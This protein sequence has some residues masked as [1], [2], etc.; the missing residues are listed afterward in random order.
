MAY[1]DKI[2][3]TEQPPFVELYTITIGEEVGLY[4]SAKEDVTHDFN[5]YKAR[6]IKRGD[7]KVTKDLRSTRLSIAAPLEPYGLQF[8]S[9]APCEP[10]NIKIVRLFTDDNLDFIEV[11]NGTVLSVSITDHIATAEVEASTHIF[12][13]KLP[14]LVYQA[15]CNFM[16]FD[17]DCGADLDT[18]KVPAIVTVEDPA[19]FLTSATFGT[20]PMGYLNDGHIQFLNDYRLIVS[21]V[22]NSI[23]IQV[24]FDSRL[25]TGGSIEAWPGCDKS[26][27]TCRDKFSN[28][29]KFTGFPY[30]PS[31]NPVI[32]GF[33]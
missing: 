20:Y 7:L 16:V 9:N 24:P 18:Y 31:S 4:T 15:R 22:G 5:I 30:I 17:D 8:I 28:L 25:V 3:R 26:W 23:S 33:K 19:T 12:R 32:W 27:E 29:D 14:R 10:V 11:F 2:A 6:P 21:H 13:N 1:N